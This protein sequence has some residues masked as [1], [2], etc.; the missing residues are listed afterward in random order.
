VAR[1]GVNEL[2]DIWINADSPLR[3][4]ITEAT[5]SLDQELQ[6]DPFRHSESREGDVRIL[7]APPLAILF[8]EIAMPRA[9]SRNA[10]TLLV[11]CLSGEEIQSTGGV[12]SARRELER[13]GLLEE[14]STRPTRAALRRRREFLPQD[15]PLSRAALAQFRR[16]VAGDRDV[17]DA[18]RAAYRELAAAGLMEAMH[19]F[20]GR[21]ESVYR[22]TGRKGQALRGAGWIRPTAITCL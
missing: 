4:K 15:G 21:D 11:R 9:L 17:T 3:Q 22:L 16:H 6:V 5:Q 10:Q 12:I 13:A 7:F 20:A 14:G 18:N 8:E 1:G 2:A 19:R